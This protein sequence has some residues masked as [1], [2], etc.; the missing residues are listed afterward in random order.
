MLPANAVKCIYADIII[1]MATSGN[2]KRCVSFIMQFIQISII[3]AC[4]V[5]LTSHQP[6]HLVVIVCDYLAFAL[7]FFL[8]WLKAYGIF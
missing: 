5:V 8:S 7:A 3:T 4:L 1:I 2:Q 6:T